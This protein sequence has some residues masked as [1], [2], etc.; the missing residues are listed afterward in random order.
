MGIWNLKSLPP[1]AR[2][3]PQWNDGDM[4]SDGGQIASQS[5][6]LLTGTVAI[7]FHTVS[8]CVDKVTRAPPIPTVRAVPCPGLDV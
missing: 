3:K 2:Q 8:D 1:V 4:E 7:K 6:V 5:P